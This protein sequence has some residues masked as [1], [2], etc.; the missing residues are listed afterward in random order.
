MA[1]D[2]TNT[3]QQRLLRVILA[4]GGHECEGVTPGEIA[5]A[6]QAHPAQITR[7]LWNLR[8]GGFAEQI[9]ATGRW[10]LGPRPI[11]IFCAFAD[12]VALRQRQLDE[13]RQRYTRNPH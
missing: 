4:L 1:T 5:A 6:V 3:S 9:E 12:G 2:Y 11:Q 7:D 13:T 8:E 10:R